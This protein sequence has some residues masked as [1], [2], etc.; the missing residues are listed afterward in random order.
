MIRYLISVGDAASQLLNA[1]VFCS[2]NA[3]ESLSGRCHSKRHTYF[4]G[5]LRI[6]VNVLFWFQEDHCRFAYER[7]L[8]RARE[9]LRRHYEGEI[10]VRKVI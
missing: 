10:H 4:Y 1:L 2:M 6:F 9:L 5:T 3:N 7:D 8:E